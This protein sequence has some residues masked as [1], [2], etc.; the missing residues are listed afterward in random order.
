M[1]RAVQVWR[2]TTVTM[3]SVFMSYL[4]VCAI[5]SIYINYLTND[6]QP[7]EA[8]TIIIPHFS[9]RKWRCNDVMG[10]GPSGRVWGSNPGSLVTD[11][12]L[13][14][15]FFF[16]FLASLPSTDLGGEG[17]SSLVIHLPSRFYWDQHFCA[18]SQ[19]LVLA[20]IFCE[21]FIVG[22]GEEVLKG[23]PV[24]LL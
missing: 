18:T 22:N 10:P 15:S 21:N 20:L 24:Q 6:R 5:L 8:D 23:N 3:A 14:T 13:L 16:F 12:E 19:N 9:L 11:S 7:C 4:S 2:S 1:E 17:E